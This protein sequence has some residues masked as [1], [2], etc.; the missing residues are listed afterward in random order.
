[1][2]TPN[3]VDLPQKNDMQAAVDGL[4]RM[5]PAFLDNSVTIAKIRRANYD[6]LIAEGFTPEQALVLCTKST[7]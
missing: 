4:R 5:L 3:I 7:L 6:A 1:M 2:T